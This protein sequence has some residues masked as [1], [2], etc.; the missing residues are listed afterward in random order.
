MFNIEYEF[1][2]E[3]QNTIIVRYFEIH[4]QNGIW[5][6]ILESKMD[7]FCEISDNCKKIFEV[8][9]N[10]FTIL[11]KDKKMIKPEYAGG[12]AEMNI[13]RDNTKIVNP[14]S[15]QNSE[16]YNINTECEVKYLFWEDPR[17]E[18]VIY[19]MLEDYAQWIQQEYF[20]R[21]GPMVESGD[22]EALAEYHALGRELISEV[23]MH[24]Y[25]INPIL[26]DVVSKQSD[27]ETSANWIEV[28]LIQHGEHPCEEEFMLYSSDSS[29]QNYS[30]K[31]SE[32]SSDSSDQNY[33]LKKLEESFY[34]SSLTIQPLYIIIGA[35]AIGGA[36]AGVIAVTKRGSK[37]PKPT[38]QKPKPAKKEPA[39]KEETSAF[40]DNCG[41][42]LRL[43]AKF[44]GS[45]GT[46]IA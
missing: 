28:D 11:D 42:K 21:G 39:K 22:R 14:S 7:G 6:I 35:V 4:A 33:S 26:K 10:S 17:Q 45:C 30:L 46:R 13:I 25:S 8:M 19:Y 29:D 41:N 36:I 31:K 44:C 37:T 23:I 32:S 9:K 5:T 3:F 18:D 34:E 20:L 2:D 40:C 24:E 12:I 15:V 1:I 27:I 16:S 43:T 38:K